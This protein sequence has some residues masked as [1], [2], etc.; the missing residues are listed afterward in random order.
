MTLIPKITKVCAVAASA[1]ILSL[2]AALHAQTVVPFDGTVIPV[3]I[4]TVSSSGILAMSSTGTELGSEQSGGVSATVGIVATG[5]VPT[6]L[7]T[8]P[9]MSIKPVTYVGTPTVSLKYT[10]TGGANQAYTSVSSQHTSTN[11]LGN[12]ITLNAKAVD[13]TGFT[14]GA[15]RLQTTA[16]CQQ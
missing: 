8:A 13:I 7:F 15:Y 3:C 6:I 4:L 2:P 1:I 10:S 11:P 5:G 12:S 9:T 16:T 14:A